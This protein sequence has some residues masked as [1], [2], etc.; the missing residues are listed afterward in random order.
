MNGEQV[1]SEVQLALLTADVR[2]L[3]PLQG[4]TVSYACVE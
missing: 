2:R 1:S 3:G 4:K